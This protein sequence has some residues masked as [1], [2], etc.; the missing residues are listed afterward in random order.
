MGGKGEDLSPQRIE[1]V[2]TRACYVR[3]T[4]DCLVGYGSGDVS[5]NCATSQ[6]VVLSRMTGK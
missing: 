3:S 4:R 2:E 6:D 5:A 1:E